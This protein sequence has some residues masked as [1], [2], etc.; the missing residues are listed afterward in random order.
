MSNY[1]FTAEQINTAIDYI[2]ADLWDFGGIDGLVLDFTR[3]D[4]NGKVKIYS[5]GWKLINGVIK[6]CVQVCM[7]VD[8][9]HYHSIF[10]DV[11]ESFINTINDIKLGLLEVEGVDKARVTAA[12]EIINCG[13]HFWDFIAES[14]DDIGVEAVRGAMVEAIEVAG[15]ISNPVSKSKPVL[16]T[17][18]TNL[19]EIKERANEDLAFIAE[20]KEQDLINQLQARLD[21]LKGLGVTFKPEDLGL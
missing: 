1:T 18:A 5:Y 9:E 4:P 17:K 3:N 20:V 11:K 19:N 21:K 12:W 14:V 13:D 6:R 2:E 8:S 16:K 15:N 7:P 10:G